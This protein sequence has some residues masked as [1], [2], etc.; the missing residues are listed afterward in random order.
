[1]LRVVDGLLAVLRDRRDPMERRWRKLVGLADDCRQAK[2]DKLR[3]D[4]MSDFVELMAVAAEDKLPLDPAT[5]PRPSWVGRVLFRQFA[6]IYTRKDHGPN[7]GPALGGVWARLRAG[8]SFSRGRGAVPRLHA[9]LPETT[10]EKLEQPVGPLP[11]DAEEI[12]ERYYTLKIGALQ[13]CGPANFGVAFWEGLE[14]LAL[15]FPVLC[16]VSRAFTDVP[17]AEAIVKALSIVDDHFGFNKVLAT[18]RNRMSLSILA[19]QGEL[20]KLIAWYSR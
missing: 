6:A 15:T 4:Q 1:M 5:L 18:L 12:L 16:W 9:W 11:K 13:F 7:R 3:D 8:A 10:F 20:A 17:R 14:A 19:G 2:V